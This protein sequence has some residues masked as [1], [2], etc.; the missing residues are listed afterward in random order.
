MWNVPTL[1]WTISLYARH[2][3]C[4]S[5]E[6]LSSHASRTSSTVRG[7]SSNHARSVDNFQYQAGFV[8]CTSMEM[9]V[10]LSSGPCRMGL[11]QACREQQRSIEGSIPQGAT[12]TCIQ[13]SVL[14]VRILLG[15]GMVFTD[16][17][18]DVSCASSKSVLV[19]ARSSREISRRDKGTGRAVSHPA[20]PGIGFC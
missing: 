1:M 13:R 20:V 14:F 17:F 5:R 12:A 15:I 11:M 2:E 16:I 6:I 4:E 8:R 19:G 9:K 18:V 10:D 7:T 3:T